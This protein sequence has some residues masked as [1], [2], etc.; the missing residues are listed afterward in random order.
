[1]N[2]TKWIQARAA[3]GQA[4]NLHAVQ[5]ERPDL[6]KQAFA[7]PS[8]RGWRRTLIGAGVDPYE[9]E[10]EYEDQVECR[11]CGYASAVLGTHLKAHHGVTGEEYLEEFGPDCELSSE[12]FRAARFGSRPIAGIEHWESIWSRL[13]VVDWIIR[14]HE[15]GV[16]LNFH[17]LRDIGQP[18]AS[19][20]WKLFGSW[21]AALQAA[22]F[23]P[24]EE[25]AIPPFQHWTEELVIERLRKFA[26]EKAADW[27]LSM[28]NELRSA[29]LRFF[30]GP[31]A[32]AKAAGLRFVDIN[33]RALSSDSKIPRLVASLRKLEGLKG[34]ARRKRLGTIYHRNDENRR[35]IQ[36]RY[37]SLQRLAEREGINPRALAIQT[38][39]DE[40]D[41]HHDL[42]LLEQA[43]KMLRHDTL[44]RGHKTLY[45]VISKT[46]WGRERLASN[47]G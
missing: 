44:K 1:M 21:D 36:Y 45:N 7:G 16:S 11:I 6:L 41:V 38:Y 30:G 4:L 37:G 10:H 12:W 18:L 25:R 22:G 15:E 42:D 9:I 35:I 20:G 19:A 17:G 2:G 24:D 32:A 13:Y 14:L 23:D 8:P 40:D 46:G 39:R 43:G 31:E 27:R 33:H 47:S 5:R 29:V 3:S 26:V 34:R 28:S